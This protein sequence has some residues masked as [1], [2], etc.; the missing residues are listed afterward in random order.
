MADLRAC[1]CERCNGN[2]VH[3]STRFRHLN[4]GDSESDVDSSEYNGSPD[5]ES[6][7]S[8]CP[9]D[10]E[11]SSSSASESEDLD[12]LPDHYRSRVVQ[13]A[14]NFIDQKY[15]TNCTESQINQSLRMSRR[16]VAD[17]TDE[18]D[19]FDCIPKDF[20]AAVGRTKHL[21][22]GMVERHACVKDHYMYPIDSKETEC[23]F[24]GCGEPRYVHDG[25]II[26]FNS[27]IYMHDTDN[28]L[29]DCI[30][31]THK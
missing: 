25:I 16:L 6:E 13:Y 28:I 15:A 23:P 18:L 26:P 30:L 7:S 8:D 21:V 17:A 27:N 31:Y 9:S 24:N 11:D 1:Y 4:L 2:F 12:D 19:V 20:Q 29:P 3:R 22:L 5:E 10:S 14:C